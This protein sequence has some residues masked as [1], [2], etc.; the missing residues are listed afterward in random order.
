MEML[1]KGQKLWQEI[2]YQMAACQASL[3]SAGS[4][5]LAELR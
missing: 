4:V 2:S 1:K 5:C 3:S